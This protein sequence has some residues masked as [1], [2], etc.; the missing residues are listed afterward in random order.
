[1]PHTPAALALTHWRAAF[2]IFER[3]I[4]LNSCSL[5][6]LS[7]ASRE[8]VATY[9][10]QWEARGAANWYDVWWAALDELRTRYAAL[11]G[12]RPSEIALHPSVS[13]VLGVVGSALDTSSR[14]R[15]VTTTLDFPTLTY[16]WLP[17]DV[18]VVLLES[19]DG[20]TVPPERFAN[21]VDDRTALVATSHVYFTSGAIQDIA[22]IAEIARRRGALSLIDGYHGVGQVPTDVTAAGVD[23]YCSGGL[24]WLLG[25]SGICFLYARAE[26][27]HALCPTTT[28]WFAH[29][30]QFAFDPAHFTPHDDARRFES[31]T[32]SMASV[33]AQLG[34]L[35]VLEAAGAPAIRAATSALAEDLIERAL[36]RGI[37]PRMASTP[38]TRSGIVMLPSDDPKRDVARLA[39]AGFIVDAR[40]GHVRVSP[41]FYNL[42][43]DH[44]AMLEHFAA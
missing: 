2:P 24:K 32:P 9:L 39:E 21:A 4:Y 3:T 7:R 11:V 15:I 35:D 23:F 42:A 30:D 19:E 43:D 25:G 33:H 40:P 34:G 44:I 17:K 22:A 26:T 8:R 28:G 1:M 36:A 38:A 37:T 41:Y 20:V 27:T 18:E 13:S 12:A 10:D 29:H 16:Q 14:R 5:G 6:P 31:G